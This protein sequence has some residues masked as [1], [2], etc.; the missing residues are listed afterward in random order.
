M[1]ARALRLLLALQL[2]LAGGLWLALAGSWRGAGPLAAAL[3][4]LAALALLLLARMLIT[5]HNF[6]LSWRFRSATPAP[7][8]ASPAQRWRLFAGEFA[9]TM[10]TS[11]WHMAWPRACRHSAPGAGLPVLLVHGY[12]CNR[13]YWAPLSRLLARSGISHAALDL[14]P[15]GADIDDFVPA[16]HAALEELCA[17]SGSTQ[18]VIVAHSMGGLVAR[19]Y[20]RRHGAQRVARVVTLGTPHHGTALAGLGFGRNARQMGRAGPLQ[21]G[22]WLAQLAAAEDAPRRALF[23]SIFSHHDNIVAPQTSAVLPGAKNIAFGGVGHVALGRDLRVLQCVLD[24]I[25]LASAGAT[26]S[27]SQ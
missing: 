23:T 21:P 11:S 17:R 7:F 22:A 20:L 4:G 5:A 9:A 26:T 14:E 16:L 1:I 12:V 3:A 13:G 24:E 10:L 18:V 25:A 8:H 27:L 19:A 6:W 2:L 15:A